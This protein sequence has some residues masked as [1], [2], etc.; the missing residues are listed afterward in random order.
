[1][2]AKAVHTETTLGAA[3]TLSS[4]RTTQAVALLSQ[5][6]ATDEPASPVRKKAQ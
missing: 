3:L 1:V 6:G 5:G 4:R 2:A